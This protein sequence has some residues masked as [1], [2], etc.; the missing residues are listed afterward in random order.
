MSVAPSLIDVPSE[1]LRRHRRT[2]PVPL[3]PLTHPM[4]VG[5]FLLALAVCGAPLGVSFEGSGN[6]AH[7]YLDYKP[8]TRGLAYVNELLAEY[9]HRIVNSSLQIELVR[10]DEEISRG[11][12]G[13]TLWVHER[14]N[15][16]DLDAK[17]SVPAFD[18]RVKLPFA[19]GESLR[20]SPDAVFKNSLYLKL[21]RTPTPNVFLEVTRDGHFVSHSKI[22]VDIP[23]TRIIPMKEDYVEYPICGRELSLRRHYV[24][25]R[26][27][28]VICEL[29][30][31]SFLRDKRQLALQWHFN[32]ITGHSVPCSNEMVPKCQIQEIL[33]F[34][35]DVEF[36]G[37]SYDE[38]I[39]CF[40]L[41]YHNVNRY[42]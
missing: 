3:P 20:V 19:E 39:A 6:D 26:Y 33:T 15:L 30:Y 1:C 38:L 41:S 16:P 35:R 32:A 21:H 36:I 31:G 24:Q 12:M 13:L 7:V 29:R 40:V 42:I 2:T 22:T 5:T 10:A 18:D 27:E 34:Q 23:C 17:R 9:A 8:E 14:W 28:D 11:R 37:D 25:R 4:T